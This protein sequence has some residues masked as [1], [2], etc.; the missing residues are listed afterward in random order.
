MPIVYIDPYIPGAASLS[1]TSY[2]CDGTDTTNYNTT[3]SRT[4]TYA[5]PF[6]WDDFQNNSSSATSVGSTGTTLSADTEIRIKG[7]TMADMSLSLGSCYISGDWLYPATGNTDFATNWTNSQLQGRY[8]YFSGTNVDAMFP[9]GVDTFPLIFRNGY[10]FTNYGT[11]N[12]RIYLAADDINVLADAVQNSGFNSASSPFSNVHGIKSGYLGTHA[13]S[14]AD[15]YHWFNMNGRITKI[16]SGWTSETEQNG[17]SLIVMTQS[18][19]Y[20]RQRFTGSSVHFDMG[21]AALIMRTNRT[22][23]QF[24]PQKTGV[25][26]KLGMFHV[27]SSTSLSSGVYNQS[28]NVTCITAITT[29]DDIQIEATGANAVNQVNLCIS[30]LRGLITRGNAGSGTRIK[31]GSIYQNTYTYTTQL[32]FVV[33]ENI[34]AATYEFLNGSSYYSRATSSVSAALT[35]NRSDYANA[36]HIYPTIVY[37]TGE[38]SGHWL[39]NSSENNNPKIGT[40]FRT[41]TNAKAYANTLSLTA[42]NWWEKLGLSM[43]TNYHKMPVQSIGKLLCGGQNYKTTTNQLATTTGITF[44]SASTVF[45][46]VFGCETNDYDNKP[47]II[48]PNGSADSSCSC[49]AYNETVNSNEVVVIQGGGDSGGYFYYPIEI[50]APTTFDPTSN[51]LRVKIILSRSSNAS[52]TVV[53]YFC[54]R[55]DDE[56][57]DTYVAEVSTGAST[58]ST[59]QASPTAIVHNVSISAS[60][61]RKIN[62]VLFIAR[63]EP[64]TSTTSERLYIHDAYAETY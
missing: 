18:D 36:T 45:P 60:G 19:S 46:P 16:S 1:D 4:G 59:D 28:T 64:A 58:I 37:R 9:T 2:L 21:R 56:S 31:V 62:S 26:H 52:S 15:K 27:P 41:D 54:Y 11:S 33:K 39:A 34:G 57:G 53:K 43:N 24:I 8:L 30:T 55:K 49:L 40:S 38:P 3:S 20:E 32:G 50:Q 29:G 7:K 63:F 44:S 17:Y 51:S 22:Y 6:R 61:S 42:A 47:L 14:N 13:L 35:S 48:I 10:T 12:Q 23:W 5:N 25:T